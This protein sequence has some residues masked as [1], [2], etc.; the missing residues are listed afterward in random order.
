MGLAENKAVVR[1]FVEAC[2]NQQDLVAFEDVIAD[3]VVNH[4][5]PPGI[6]TTKE[7]WRQ[8]FAIFRAG[9]PDMHWTIESMV[10]EDDLVVVRVT[11]RATHRGDFFGIPPTNRPVNV[12]SFHA[13]RVANGQITEHWGVMAAPGVTA[14]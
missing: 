5:A 8:N 12:A 4:Y 14:D 1:R 7:G 11:M 9:F 2:L 3:E 13:L 10:A 6:P